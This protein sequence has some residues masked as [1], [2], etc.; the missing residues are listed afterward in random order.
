MYKTDRV[1][2]GFILRRDGVPITG[3][4]YPY[5]E[6][7][8]FPAQA[9]VVIKMT[10]LTYPTM[11]ILSPDAKEQSSVVVNTVFRI[12][13]SDDAR[14]PVGVEVVLDPNARGTETPILVEDNQ[15]SFTAITNYM[16][17]FQG[18]DGEMAKFIKDKPNV[19]LIDYFV[20]MKGHIVTVI[21]N[22]DEQRQLYRDSWRSGS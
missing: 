15:Q 21:L 7:N 2:K 13:A 6:I 5:S 8:H 19:D 3:V 9:Y 17:G 20:M 22:T 14:Y 4:E 18:K 12:A 16:K 1:T 10:R 11:M